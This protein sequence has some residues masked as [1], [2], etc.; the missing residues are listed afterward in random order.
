[1]LVAGMGALVGIAIAA[2]I[3]R[4]VLSI[5]LRMPLVQ[6]CFGVVGA[7]GFVLAVTAVVVP[8][9]ADIRE[10]SVASRRAWLASRAEPMWRRAYLDVGLI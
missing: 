3:C 5:D 4:T 2:A 9:I 10:R 6:E 8:T 7:A 1:G